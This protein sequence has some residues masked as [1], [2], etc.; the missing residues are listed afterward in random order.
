MIRSVTG[1][2]TIYVVTFAADSEQE[3]AKRAQE[4]ADCLAA[5]LRTLG[6][7]PDA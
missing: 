5:Q 3:R 7:E 6:V 2:G 4:R 1:H